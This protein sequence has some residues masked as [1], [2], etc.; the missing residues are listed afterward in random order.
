VRGRISTGGSVFVE[1]ANGPDLRRNAWPERRGE[2]PGDRRGC[3]RWTQDRK[4]GCRGRNLAAT[5]AAPPAASR[6]AVQAGTIIA[7][8]CLGCNDQRESF[9]DVKRAL[10]SSSEAPMPA[11]KF[12]A[13]V[14][15]RRG[16]AWQRIARDD[17]EAALRRLLDAQPGP[18][19]CSC[20]LPAGEKPWVRFPNPEPVQR[21]AEPRRRG[22]IGQ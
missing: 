19:F 8:S 14:Q 22:G 3:R 11:W 4:A 1:N 7:D 20:V 18:L 10:P 12:A 17:D 5:A 13:W 21:T 15:S 6:L 2:T 9:Q 16:G